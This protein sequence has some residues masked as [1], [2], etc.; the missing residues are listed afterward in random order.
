MVVF[1]VL[2][3]CVRLSWI[4]LAPFS[5]I[6]YHDVFCYKLTNH[7]DHRRIKAL[8]GVLKARASERVGSEL[9]DYSVNAYVQRIMRCKM[10]SELLEM[11]SN[12]PRR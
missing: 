8:T 12:V 10:S 2:L 4:P 5:T 1:D 7:D 3:L 9:L 6:G 11:L